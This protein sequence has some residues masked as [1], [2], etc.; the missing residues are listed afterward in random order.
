[1]VR[2]FSRGEPGR[3][4]HF[5]NPSHRFLPFLLPS[6]G[7]AAGLFRAVGPHLEPVPYRHGGIPF[8]Q[9]PIHTAHLRHHLI[10]ARP[11][12]EADL[13]AARADHNRV[14]RGARA[15]DDFHGVR[16]WL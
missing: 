10:P 5:R 9:M 14:H 4:G 15:V 1:M 2:I 13:V 3:R 11:G 16:L 12:A 8:H 7:R 6:A